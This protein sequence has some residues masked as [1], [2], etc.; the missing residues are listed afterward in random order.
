MFAGLFKRSRAHEVPQELYGSVVAQARL[1]VFFTDFGFEDTVTGRFDV[2]LLHLFLLSR[3]LVREDTPLS[4]SLNQEIF[5]HFTEET[6]RALR[7]L[8]VGDTT[9]PKRKKKMIHS[10]YALVQDLSGPL[11]QSSKTSE[12]LAQLVSARFA[13]KRKTGP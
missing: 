2:V 12:G 5:D 10:F 8:G 13:R 1:P 11:D 9:V 6:D 7:E 3:R 4:Q